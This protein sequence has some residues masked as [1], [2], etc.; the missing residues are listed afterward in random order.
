MTR[1]FFPAVLFLLAALPL[2]GEE[3]L[4]GRIDIDMEPVYALS[5][6]APY[7]LDA[8]T[9]RRRALE[10][11]ALNFAAMIYGWDFSYEAGEKE[12]GLAENLDMERRGAVVFGDGRLRVTDADL[13]GAHFSVWA[14]YR[15]S[16]AQ[17]RRMEQ[18]RAGQNRII[19]GTGRADFGGRGGGSDAWIRGKTAA[20]EDAARAAIRAMLRGTERNRPR[21]V[22]GRIALAEFPRFYF[23][24]GAWAVAARFHVEQIEVE[25]FPV[26]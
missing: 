23:E 18:W 14:D 20:L 5:P 9:A 8:E 7:P 24:R 22:R 19:Q 16:A 26:Y 17:L 10:E 13:D 11:A 25:P 4:R 3:V 12:R 21:R 2:A 1:L 15:M 6:E